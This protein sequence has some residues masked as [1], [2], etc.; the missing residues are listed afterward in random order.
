[1]PLSGL[2][3]FAQIICTYLHLSVSGQITFSYVSGPDKCLSKNFWARQTR[4]SCKKSGQDKPASDIIVHCN[5]W[6]MI[7]IKGT[8]IQTL[9]T[10]FRGNCKSFETNLKQDYEYPI[11]PLTQIV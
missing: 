11:L 6:Q 9:D 3:A 7:Q 4:L 10:D 8:N 2:D 1:M 5:L